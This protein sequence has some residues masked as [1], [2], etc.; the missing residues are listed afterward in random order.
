PPPSIPGLG[1]VSGFD[2]RLQDRTGD[3]DR[4]A[5]TTEQL[6]AAA[7]KH[8]DLAEVRPTSAPETP[9]LYVDL[10]RVKAKAMGIPIQDLFYTVGGLLGSYY[11]NDFAKFGRVLQVRLQSDADRRMRPE[12]IG[13]FY[14]RNQANEM[15]PLSTVARIEWVRGP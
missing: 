1:Q 5:K 14:V 7:A 13:Q 4:L 15:V 6:T 10:D 11:V 3:R 2:Y 12:D 9:L 8:P